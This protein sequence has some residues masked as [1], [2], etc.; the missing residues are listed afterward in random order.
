VAWMIRD[1][2]G[3]D[4]SRLAMLVVRCFGEG[5]GRS[6]LAKSLEDSM[7]R[8]RIAFDESGALSGFVIARRVADIVEIDLLGVAPE[9]RREGCAVALLEDLIERE[10]ARG[11]AELRLEL[12][13]SN[14]SAHALYAGLGFVVVGTRSRYYPDGENATLLTCSSERAV[15]LQPRI[16]TG[17]ET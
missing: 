13:E 4:L 8:M 12:R 16:E 9:R 7:S 10:V 11:A 5:W 3:S 2:R 1:V 14:H 15:S 6:A 17:T